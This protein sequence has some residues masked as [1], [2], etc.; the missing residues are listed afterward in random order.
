MLGE[1]EAF[2]AEGGIGHG[3]S[4]TSTYLFMDGK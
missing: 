4:H 2:K 3:P 1:Y